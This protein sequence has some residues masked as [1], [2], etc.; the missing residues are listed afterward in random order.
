MEGESYSF[1]P[2]LGLLS[3]AFPDRPAPESGGRSLLIRDVLFGAG[4]NVDAAREAG[5]VYGTS[6][7][8]GKYRIYPSYPLVAETTRLCFGLD[9]VPKGKSSL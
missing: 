1:R 7:Y 4:F 2:C 6:I 5:P 8:F 9:R 3:K